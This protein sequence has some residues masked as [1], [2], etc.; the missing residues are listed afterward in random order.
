MENAEN[1][2]ITEDGK[3][4]KLELN[5]LHDSMSMHHIEEILCKM[6][7][8]DYRTY[9]EC[10]SNETV[11]KAKSTERKNIS[12][13]KVTEFKTNIK[14]NIKH[15]INNHLQQNYQALSQTEM[16]EFREVLQEF[17][18]PKV[19]YDIS[20][21]F[22][23]NNR[24]TEQE[25]YEHMKV[26]VPTILSR[27]FHHLKYVNS[28]PSSPVDTQSNSSDRLE[29]PEILTKTLSLDE[30]PS[31][32]SD[33]NAVLMA[34]VTDLLLPRL[35]F[36]MFPC[37]I[38]G[39][40]SVRTWK[41]LNIR[42]IN[43]AIALVIYGRYL[44][45]PEFP[46]DLKNES[47]PPPWFMV[48]KFFYQFGLPGYAAGKGSLK[49]E[50][51]KKGLEENIGNTHTQTESVQNADA[52]EHVLQL[53]VS[54]VPKELCELIVSEYKQLH[55]MMLGLGQVQ[56]HNVKNPPHEKDD[57]FKLEHLNCV[58]ELD[59]KRPP[60]FTDLTDFIYKYREAF[61]SGKF[62]EY[63]FVSKGKVEIEILKNIAR[64]GLHYNEIALL[65][66]VFKA[67][68]FKRLKRRKEEGTD[69]PLPK[70]K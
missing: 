24:N 17:L 9:F 15:A 18:F 1:V 37:T 20:I 60:R 52:Q 61:K 35:K 31:Y 4:Q 41:G 21:D 22:R 59:C 19:T 58:V 47:F 8:T 39:L 49:E 44:R 63:P 38:K 29:L 68:P 45:H 62:D 23:E 10:D 55:L 54:P 51:S 56:F 6:P 5:E 67:D 50:K 57:S 42:F 14:Y 46:S 12:A 40:R 33:S 65:E 30:I 53:E 26:R 2:K 70:A 69:R 16:H 7:A 28:I 11:G 36:I 3:K 66:T 43:Y 25:F 13:A 32:E 48:A 27:L 64:N 34:I